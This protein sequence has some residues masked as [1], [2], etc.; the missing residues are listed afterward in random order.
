M[1]AVA[2]VLAIQM[3][4]VAM[5]VVVREVL[6]VGH[7]EPQIL[8]AEVV[9]MAYQALQA[10]EVLALLFLDIQIQEQLLLVQV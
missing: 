6:L 7:L 2:V 4:A 8:E 3:L 1:Q 10:L 9:Q 5:V